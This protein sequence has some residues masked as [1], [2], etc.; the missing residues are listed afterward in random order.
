MLTS[1][2][3]SIGIGTDND[4]CTITL[5]RPSSLNA[6]NLDMV[7]ALLD[8]T[9]KLK[10]ASDIRAIILQGA[11]DHFMAGGDVKGFKTLLDEE[12]K[13]SIIRRA[14]EDELEDVHRTIINMR[15]LPIPIIAS[16]R[17]AVAGAG[18][19][20]LLACDLAICSENTILTLA[21]RHIGTSPDGGST[22]F[23][24]RTIGLKKAMEV[25]LLG[26]RFDA[27]QAFD[28]GLVNCVVPDKLLAKETKLIAERLAKGPAYALGE[29]KKLIN[30]SLNANLVEQLTAET[31]AFVNCA[32][33]KDF[34]EGVCAF[35]EKRPP[36]FE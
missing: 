17:G 22:Y 14:F 5:N 12:K 6:L 8:I 7:S 25:A 31:K 15:T 24:P 16:A 32:I 23:L 28:L 4:V 1:P 21:Y 18:L 36:N 34:Y 33:R 19:S 29:T 2:N 30:G 10:D 9:T 27:Q 11:G 35:T 3:D 13:T 20:F 26:D